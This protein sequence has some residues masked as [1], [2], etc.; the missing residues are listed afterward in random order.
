MPARDW[1]PDG[2]RPRDHERPPPLTTGVMVDLAP[3]EVHRCES[4][5][6]GGSRPAV[7]PVNLGST[8]ESPGRER[9]YYRG[10]AARVLGRRLRRDSVAD[11]RSLEQALIKGT[12]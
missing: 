6:S 11:P 3:Y 5:P 10:R 8:P 4:K 1:T 7:G 12:F 2:S 9:G